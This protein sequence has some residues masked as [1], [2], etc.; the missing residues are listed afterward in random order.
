VFLAG[1]FLSLA[2]T[3][4]ITISAVT[5]VEQA[6]LPLLATYPLW[7]AIAINLLVA[8]LV[9]Y[10]LTYYVFVN[11]FAVPASSIL[12]PVDRLR[13][14]AFFFVVLT[15]VSTVAAIVNYVLQLIK[16]QSLV[17]A[18][19]STAGLD[20]VT[21]FLLKFGI[22]CVLLFANSYAVI[23]YTFVPIPFLTPVSFRNYL[24]V[25]LFVYYMAQLLLSWS[26]VNL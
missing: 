3:I 16:V 26:I 17:S 25:R 19:Q 23:S 1:K 4:L 7:Q 22:G 15:F 2:Q 5:S 24:Y 12:P 8:S 21:T 10:A 9:A 13:S 6:L 18:G 20:M 14:D 11:W